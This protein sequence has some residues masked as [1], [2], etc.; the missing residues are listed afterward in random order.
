MLTA[1]ANGR[2]PRLVLRRLSYGAKVQLW[3]DACSIGWAG[4]LR[5][6]PPVDVRDIEHAIT[7]REVLDR[8][9]RMGIV[10]ASMTQRIAVR[11]GWRDVLARDPAARPDPLV[12][13][14]LGALW[15][16]EDL[17]DGSGGY[18]NVRS[19]PAPTVEWANAAARTGR[20]AV[21]KW[22]HARMGDTAWS[23]ETMDLA[24]GSGNLDLVVWMS[25]NRREEFTHQA[26]ESAARRGSVAVVRWL[27]DRQTPTD[28]GGAIVAAAG[29][30]HM[31]VLALLHERF[32]S[33][34]FARQ[35]AWMF[36]SVRDLRVLKWLHSLGLIKPQANPPRAILERA[37]LNGH[38]E[39]ARWVCATFGIAPDEI[40]FEMVCQ[41]GHAAV[42]GWIVAEFG[43]AV[44]QGMFDRACEADNADMARLI[45]ARHGIVVDAE[46][47]RRAVSMDATR[48][49]GVLVEHDGSLARTIIR[50][51][52]AGG[53]H[54][55]VEWLCARYRRHFTQ[56]A[57]EVAVACNQTRIAELLLTAVTHVAWN[58]AAVQQMPRARQDG[59][60]QRV[61]EAYLQRSGA[62]P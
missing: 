15:L 27:V 35:A 9:R 26:L 56:D 8:M 34:A 49:I 19:R 7:S 57:L 28:P 25:R 44:D 43:M 36:S 33:D 12:A 47:A 51:A 13:I 22:L 24:A 41:E 5:Q 54:D 52:V 55:L 29:A 58:A 14:E 6:L 40:M 2:L 32:G 30:G 62:S 17:V 48:V 4:D 11:H 53:N 3:A 45:M 46:S 37:A 60:M 10:P 16:L 31:D 20:L 38:L 61:L 42:A 50:M 21:V 18:G 59:Q 1:L 23:A 39:T